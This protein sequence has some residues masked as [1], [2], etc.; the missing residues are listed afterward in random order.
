MNVDLSRVPPLPYSIFQCPIN[1]IRIIQCIYEQVRI[2]AATL[3]TGIYAWRSVEDI[4]FG[5]SY[6]VETQ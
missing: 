6:I 3:E 2:Q 4:L 5:G 1:S